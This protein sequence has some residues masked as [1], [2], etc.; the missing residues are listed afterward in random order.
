MADVI[1]DRLASGQRN[2][3]HL[4]AND[5]RLICNFPK[6]SALVGKQEEDLIFSFSD[7]ATVTLEDFY[8][9]YSQCNVPDFLMNGRL[10]HGKAFFAQ[11]PKR[12]FPFAHRPLPQNTVDLPEA[13][14]YIE[15]EFLH[16]ESVDTIGYAYDTDEEDI[17]S[18]LPTPDF[19]D[20]YG[21]CDD[22]N[23]CDDFH[24]SSDTKLHTE[25]ENDQPHIQNEDQKNYSLRHVSCVV[26]P[27]SA[28]IYAPYRMSY[29]AATHVTENTAA[30]VGTASYVSA[31]L[32]FLATFPDVHADDTPNAT[33]DEIFWQTKTT[34]SY[35][36][37]MP[38][39]N[40]F[41][42]FADFPD[43][44][45][46]TIEGVI[47]G[48]AIFDDMAD[49]VLAEFGVHSTHNVDNLF[50]APEPSFLLDSL[51]QDIFAAY[52][53]SDATLLN[54]PHATFTYD[55]S[56]ALMDG[57]IGID[58]I[59]NIMTHMGTS[60]TKFVARTINGVEIVVFGNNITGDTVEATLQNIGGIKAS[61]NSLE[62][63]TA[64]GW[65]ETATYNYKGS[66]YTEY[67][68]NA[69]TSTTTENDDD[70]TILVAQNTLA[71]GA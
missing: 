5:T 17:I 44:T 15:E 21:L 57:G 47:E 53:N 13:K 50:D 62:I 69:K 19:C 27:A 37:M 48:T 2:V 30:Y 3:V 52:H 18:Y 65:Q 25:Q 9:A 56:D 7:G 35:I 28:R 51:G 68:Y 60:V 67:L 10:I 49:T 63:E 11:L 45:I 34:T 29:L 41:T 42:D 26:V 70:I 71:L 1:V 61:E 12:L 39:A 66:Q 40:D 6:E 16:N 46:G 55:T 31:M 36:D 22:F 8:A 32:A 24:L 23:L 4:T 43:A 33:P 54:N 20:A 64:S 58:M 38:L 14:A 59:Q